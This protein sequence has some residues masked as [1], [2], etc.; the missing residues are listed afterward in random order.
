MK[1]VAVTGIGV[2]APGGHDA[3]S[4]FASL[5]A[6]RSAV[7]RLWEGDPGTAV[8]QAKEGGAS[9]GAPAPFDAR[10]HFPAPRRKLLDRVSQLAVV[11]A[12]QALEDASLELDDDLRRTVG[13]F[14][15]TA[16]GG[17]AS[18][19]EGYAAFYGGRADRIHPS[20]VLLAMSNAPAGWIA[21]EHGLAGPCLTYSTACSSS[22]VAIG[23]AWLRI[24]CGASTVALA[25]GAEAPLTPGTLKAWDALQALAGEDPEDLG[26]SCKPFAGD[27]TGLVLGEGA[28]VLV[29]EEW[30]HAARRGARVHGELVGYGLSTDRE[31]ILRPTVEGQARAMA[32]ALASAGVS[33]RAVGYI[34]AHGTGT[35]ANDAV[36]TA[37]IRRV[38][39]AA[40]ERVAVSST[41]SMHGHLLGA[42]GAVELVAT[43]LALRTGV[44]PPTINLRVPDP[45]CDLDY[46]PL[47]AR[48][49]QD[50]E[51]G[52]SSSFAFGGTN[53]VLVC[54]RAP[55]LA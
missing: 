47:A 36:E 39:G 18:A 48:R 4:F 6:G 40:A 13:V 45:A 51:L 41:K 30:E 25:G 7:R 8:L 24:R 20:T 9:I 22:A 23:E 28:A 12:R 10:A 55:R 19:D 15:G 38:L 52:M 34:N 50:V 11:A 49:G 21:I 3:E 27:R 29:L 37:A 53:A 44:I 42:A 35:R 31:H 46:V 5:V 1:R 32:L 43:L 16:L 2:V 26:A 33:P 17:A 14:L 54:R